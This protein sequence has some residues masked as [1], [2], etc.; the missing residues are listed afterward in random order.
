[1]TLIRI[2]LT[3][4]NP[5]ALAFFY[6]TAL[7]FSRAAAVTPAGIAGIRVADAIRLRYGNS[8]IDI[9]GFDP[10]GQKFPAAQAANDLSFQHFAIIVPDLAAAY[11]TLSGTAGWRPISANGPVKLPASSGGATAFKFRDP[12]G[13]PLEFLQPAHPQPAGIDHSAIAISDT[14]TS[15]AFYKKFGLARQA[16]SLNQGP[17]QAALDNLDSPV[18]EVTRLGDAAGRL[19]LELLRYRAPLTADT[20]H[21]A[22]N[23][24][25][26]TKL[27]FSGAAAPPQHDPD[28]HFIISEP[29]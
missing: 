23:D 4:H 11:N 19:H 2:S 29:N 5:A 27:V 9:L 10:P 6:Q 1:M 22:I 18:V 13:H 12:E 14:A 20:Q 16:G 15:V 3:A 21:P 17:E 26:A 28:G 24:V 8:E 25:A 7:G